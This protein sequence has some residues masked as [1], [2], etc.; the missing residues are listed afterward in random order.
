M[1]API[2]QC[3]RD[4]T[5]ALRPAV[6][7]EVT[8]A[9][10]GWRTTWHGPA[11]RDLHGVHRATVPAALVASPGRGPSDDPA[12]LRTIGDW[13]ARSAGATFVSAYSVGQPR[14]AELEL[15]TTIAQDPQNPAELTGVRI[16]LTDGT[17]T[18]HEVAL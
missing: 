17:T 18:E 3:E 6:P 1:L 12:A 4:L 16:H 7:F 13:T 15:L 14:V 9:A 11:G 2:R 5:L 8:A 10:G